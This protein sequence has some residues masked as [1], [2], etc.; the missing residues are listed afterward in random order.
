MKTIEELEARLETVNVERDDLKQRLLDMVLQRN[1]VRDKLDICGLDLVTAKR[2][3]DEAR[4]ELAFILA[5]YANERNEEL[6]EDALCLK[7]AGLTHQRDDA[8]T[9]LAMVEA[10]HKQMCSSAERGW[11][12]EAERTRERDEA[13]AYA[14][15]RNDEANKLQRYLNIAATERDEARAEVESL[16]DERDELLVRVADQDAELRA[17]REAYMDAYRRGVEAMREVV[18]SG[19]RADLGGTVKITREELQAIE[20]HISNIP[21][22]GGMYAPVLI[23]WCRALLDE[24]DAAY[25]RGAEAMR[26]KCIGAACGFLMGYPGYYNSDEDRLEADLLALPI[27]EEP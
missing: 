10:W 14:E 26:D 18:V 11:A 19:A 15:E 2:E 5:E 27:P 4:A 21:H 22:V 13:R 23:A 20:N 24:Q 9:Q 7:I 6:T 17:T 3:R 12:Q 25:R 8:R 16:T 1:D